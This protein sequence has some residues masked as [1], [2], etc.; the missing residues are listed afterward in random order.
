[1]RKISPAQTAVFLVLF[2]AA[3]AAGVA[4]V[5]IFPGR[6]LGDFRGVV[7]ALLG[8]VVVFGYTVAACR[9]FLGFFPLHE[10]PI[11]KGSKREFAYHVYL[12]FYLVLF[13]PLTRS[14]VVPV[15]LMKLVY[16]GLGARLG[17]NSYSAGT[18]LDPPLT[19]VGDNCIIGHDSVLICHAVE[20]EDLAL[21]GI[22]LGHNVTIGAKAVILPGVSIGDGAVVAVGAV[23]AKGTKIGANELWGGIPARRMR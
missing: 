18:L 3:I 12:L 17:A 15:P 21:A 23:V 4:T 6:M 11:D 9:I 10:G 13:Q 7:M 5:A 8:L 14:H 16:L 2:A 20:G 1:M 22:R 19:V